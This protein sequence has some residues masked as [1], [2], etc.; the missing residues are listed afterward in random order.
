MLGTIA[1]AAA[2][3][4]GLLDASRTVA[5]DAPVITPLG[6][7]LASA[8]PQVLETLSRWAETVPLGAPVLTGVL[9]LP[10]WA[11]FGALAAVLF[12]LGHKPPPRRR[13]P[14]RS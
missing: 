14:L 8:L 3:L 11:V 4:A 1:F 13:G 10:A 5:R 2:V 12:A 7:D 6:E 9:S